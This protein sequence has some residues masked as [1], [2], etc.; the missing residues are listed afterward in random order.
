ARVDMGFK[1]VFLLLGAL[2]NSYS[3]ANLLAYGPLDGTGAAVIH[4]SP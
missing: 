3:A 1:H 4:C 2:G